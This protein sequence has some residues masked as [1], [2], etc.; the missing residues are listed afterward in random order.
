M[1]QD[2]TKPK[3]TITIFKTQLD[4][5]LA[6]LGANPSHAMGPRRPTL[7]QLERGD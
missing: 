1:S 6:R 4:R 3:E 2:T 7:G 5:I